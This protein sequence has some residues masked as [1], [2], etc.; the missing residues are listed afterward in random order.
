MI[1]EISGPHRR[2]FDWFPRTR[3]VD[4]LFVLE[5]V[6]IAVVGDFDAI[7]ADVESVDDHLMLGNPLE[8]HKPIE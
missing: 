6:H 2:S 8:W 4:E 5:D 7:V 3:P 1:S